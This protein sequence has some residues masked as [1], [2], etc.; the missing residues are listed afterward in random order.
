MRAL[1]LATIS[2]YQRYI[3]PHK[4]F[5]CAYRIHTG[6]SSCSS[7]GFRAVRRYGV[8]AG[9]AILRRRTYLCGVVHRRHARL[10]R[11]SFQ[12]QRGFCD[13]GCDIPCDLSCDLP[14]FPSCSSVSDLASF[15]DCGGCDWPSRKNKKAEGE[16]Y[17]YIPPNVNGRKFG[18]EK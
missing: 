9:L 2:A 7:L 3:S 5:G 14:D 17:I 12:K 16:R 10:P 13:L 8:L 15:C 4:G 1:L 11:Y 6:R 18:P